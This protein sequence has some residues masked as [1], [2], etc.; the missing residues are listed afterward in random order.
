MCVR[1]LCF[2]VLHTEV[3]LSIFIMFVFLFLLFFYHIEVNL[4]KNDLIPQFSLRLKHFVF[5]HVYSGVSKYT[6]HYN[7][8]FKSVDIEIDKLYL[9]HSNISHTNSFQT[10]TNYDNVIQ[11]I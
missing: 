7:G 9:S 6:L 11:D 4:E 3:V 5:I 8:Y 1:S 10:N 2:P